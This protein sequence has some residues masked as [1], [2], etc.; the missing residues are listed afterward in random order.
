MNIDFV[1]EIYV[2]GSGAK[3]NLQ[4]QTISLWTLTRCSAEKRAIVLSC[5]RLQ[6]LNEH[7]QMTFDAV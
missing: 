5:L 4:N 6:V 2:I 1:I 3:G 7:G